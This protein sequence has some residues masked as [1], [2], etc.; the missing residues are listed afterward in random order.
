MYERRLVCTIIY[1]THQRAF[2]HCDESDELCMTPPKAVSAP[3]RRS[4]A[5]LA[6]ELTE[7]SERD[8]V[9]RTNKVLFGRKKV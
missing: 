4:C 9:S 8:V 7:G 3:Q 6:R 1:A 2:H 5:R